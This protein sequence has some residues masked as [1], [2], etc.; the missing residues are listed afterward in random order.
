MPE[1]N[2]EVKKRVLE[3]AM[4]AEKDCSADLNVP[5]LA[6]IAGMSDK[7]FQRTFAS[8]LGEAPKSYVRRIRLQYA[9]YYLVWSDASILQIAQSYGFLTN[10]G[11]T[12]AFRQQYGMSPAKFR[13]NKT[14]MPYLHS[15]GLQGKQDLD[16][17]VSN[18]LAVRIEEI[19]DQR[20][21]LVRHIGPTNQIT[22]PWKTLLGWARKRKLIFK[23]TEYFGIHND[24]WDEPSSDRYRYDAAMTIP[25]NFRS[26]KLVST[27]VLCGGLV[28]ALEF[29][30]TYKE[31]EMVWKRFVDQWLPV[32]GYKFRKPYAY[33]RYPFSLVN[34][35]LSGI[36]KA[37]LGQIS[38]TFCIPIE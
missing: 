1:V 30:G 18:G 9:A 20:V 21:A 11:F 17:L 19:P 29:R 37:S 7:H 15:P 4:A 22:K 16:S 3:A 10:A 14:V 27:K 28:A 23:T 24:Y 36:L 32:S 12:K 34:Q 38:A 25:A 6:E 31:A 13:Q 2:A 5:M 8:V 35:S 26:D 33:D